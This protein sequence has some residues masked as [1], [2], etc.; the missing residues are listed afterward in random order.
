MTTTITFE[1][2]AATAASAEAMAQEGNIDLQMGSDAIA[3]AAVLFGWLTEHATEAQK[4]EI[5]RRVGAELGFGDGDAKSLRCP[6]C[7]SPQP[8]LHPA[9]QYEGEVEICNDP[10]QEA[11]DAAIDE[12]QKWIGRLGALH[13][14]A[15]RM[16]RMLTKEDGQ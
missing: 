8:R 11:A 15:V 3:V 13:A 10:K 1:M 9:V 6:T 2:L 14:S 16:R 12:L 4:V 5:A 7:D